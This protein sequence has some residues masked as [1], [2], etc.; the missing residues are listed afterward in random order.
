L[1][2]YLL[3]LYEA[4][5]SK[6]MDALRTL[7]KNFFSLFLS[8]VVQSG[9]Q[10]IF[11]VLFARYVGAAGF[12]QYSYALSIVLLL[13]ILV[14]F[15]FDS[16]LVREIAK[17]KE[18]TTE[19]VG[20]S[21]LI[22]GILA[23]LVTTPLGIYFGVLEGRSEMLLLVIIVAFLTFTE[24]LSNSFTSVF[25]AYERMEIEAAANILGGIMYVGAGVGVML[26]KG[27]LHQ[28]ALALCLAP[29]VKIV[30]VAYVYKTRFS[31]GKI[32]KHLSLDWTIFKCASVFALL[33]GIGTLYGNADRIILGQYAGYEAVGWYSGAYK[34]IALVLL[35]P[36]L[37]STA[38]YPVMS[39]FFASSEAKAAE[40]YRQC[41][42]WMLMVGALVGFL[43]YLLGEQLSTLLYG[44][45][46]A[47]AGV[48][49]KVLSPF[50]AWQFPNFVNGQ[51]MIATG[52]ERLF[53]LTFAIATAMNIGLNFWLI[54]LVGY[55]GVCYSAIVPT[56]IGFVFYSWYC[57][58]KLKISYDFGLIGK[59]ILALFALILLS[60][61]VNPFGR[62]G[63]WAY[64]VLSP[65]LYL[66]MLGLLKVFSNGD[67]E[68]F[69]GMF[70][71][72]ISSFR[73][74]AVKRS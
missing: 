31:T 44:S 42:R 52:K 66:F 7:A 73:K 34:I 6:C 18:R 48:M 4:W 1:Q 68:A 71:P 47:T 36:T 29:V 40:A 37:F 21:L 3:E 19:L 17:Q 65:I 30:S 50:I 69:S 11:T 51:T 14:N 72:I 2:G 64:G 59:I 22:K 55:I 56:A 35:V 41:Y 33:G 57:H 10:V 5:I 63:L 20:K 46:F 26:F 43:I 12:G 16:F 49:L 32:S 27:T 15:G 70:A 61:L 62:V 67:K 53:S 74:V 54:P 24:T 58:R 8:R 13:N 38:M 9:L 39:R 28:I 45:A 60:F 25:R 23:L